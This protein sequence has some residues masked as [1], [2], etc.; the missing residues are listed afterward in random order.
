MGKHGGDG[1]GKRDWDRSKVRVP[2]DDGGKHTKDDD[3]G[4]GGKK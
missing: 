4:S 3:K 1:N 2:K